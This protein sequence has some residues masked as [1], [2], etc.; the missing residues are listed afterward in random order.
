M[1]GIWRRYLTFPYHLC[2]SVLA[3]GDLKIPRK[4]EKIGIFALEWAKKSDF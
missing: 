1:V 4:S 3:S 2:A